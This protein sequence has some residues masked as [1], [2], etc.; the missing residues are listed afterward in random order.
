MEGRPAV[1]PM[2]AVRV[3]L[4]PSEPVL[5]FPQWL[6]S[7]AVR[8]VIYKLLTSLWTE[9]IELLGQAG[10]GWSVFLET[11]SQYVARQALNSQPSGL[12]TQC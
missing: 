7:L 12:S 4:R 9:A 5:N 2:P 3:K 11:Q 6:L 8:E 10:V 1:A